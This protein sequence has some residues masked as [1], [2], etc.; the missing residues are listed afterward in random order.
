M[1]PLA[2]SDLSVAARA[3]MVFA[4]SERR[5]AIARLIWQADAA[6]RYRKHIGKSHPIWGNGT[7]EAAA[8]GH[9]LA[10]AKQ[11]SDNDY[12]AC[13]GVVLDGLVRH[14]ELSRA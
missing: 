13:L 14:R 2:P 10:E 3:L 9:S 7:L 12:L 1:R 8:R 5:A 6:D 11:L 4:L